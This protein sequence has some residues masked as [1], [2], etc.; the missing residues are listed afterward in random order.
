[1]NHHPQPDRPETELSERQET[2]RSIAAVFL[3]IG[4]LT[5]FLIE[6]IY[7][8][9]VTTT[10]LSVIVGLILVLF[11]IDDAHWILFRGGPS[12]PRGEPLH[13]I[14]D[15]P[16][17]IPPIDDEEMRYE[18]YREQHETER[19]DA[20]EALHDREERHDDYDAEADGGNAEW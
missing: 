3:I 17:V 19:S 16:Y 18:A 5:L 7:D 8:E 13:D 11:G 4:L 1:M 15:Y 12:K 9:P 2:I 6:M 20:R 14:T 10:M